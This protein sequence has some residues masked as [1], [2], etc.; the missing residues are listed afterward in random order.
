MGFLPS[1][2]L[3]TD[4]LGRV[5]I[6]RSPTSDHALPGVDGTESETTR[7]PPGRRQAAGMAN[8]GEEPGHGI[9]LSLL[10]ENHARN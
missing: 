2:G 9:H 1:H 4:Q 10:K 8:A 6:V 7:V 3:P 5:C